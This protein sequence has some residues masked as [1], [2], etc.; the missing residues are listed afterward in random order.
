MMTHRALVSLAVSAAVA[1][2]GL[3][4]VPL[5]A[6]GPAA[7]S[8][9]GLTGSDGWSLDK[10]RTLA[11]T[12]QRQIGVTEGWQAPRTAWAPPDLTGAWTSDSVHGIPRERPVAQGNRI[13]QT[14][15]EYKERAAR[16]EQTRQ[17]AYNASGANTGGRDRALRGHV[18]YRLTSL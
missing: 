10:H 5:I 13:F 17:S 9:A 15:E 7:T 11:R 1:V 4:S 14:E 16:E 3:I 12:I 8:D 18:T 2:L 6:Q